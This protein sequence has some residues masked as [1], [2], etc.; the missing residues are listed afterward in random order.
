MGARGVEEVGGRAYKEAGREKKRKGL[1]AHVCPNSRTS[2]GPPITQ[3]CA[4]QPV[5]SLGDTRRAP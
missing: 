4:S 1:K 3:W 5:H 2:D